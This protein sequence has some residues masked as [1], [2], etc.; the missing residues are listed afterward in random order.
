MQ[1]PDTTQ[2]SEDL[3]EL[4]DTTQAIGTH[5]NSKTFC[6]NP[7]CTSNKETPYE[8][9][10]HTLGKHLKIVFVSKMSLSNLLPL[11]VFLLPIQAFSHPNLLDVIEHCK[12][13]HFLAFCKTNFD[14]SLNNCPLLILLG[15]LIILIKKHCSAILS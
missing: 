8:D 11:L 2:I 3:S 5:L 15:V 9:W 13:H 4:S 10:Q 6:F 7:S 14:T 12:P 1:D